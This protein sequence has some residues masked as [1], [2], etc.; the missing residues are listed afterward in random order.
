MVVGATR[1]DAEALVNELIES[2]DLCPTD[3]DGESD[4]CVNTDCNQSQNNV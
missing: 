1:V 3:V 2:T 4:R